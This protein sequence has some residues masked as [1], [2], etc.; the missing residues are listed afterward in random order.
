MKDESDHEFTELSGCKQTV[1]SLGL[2]CVL[3]TVIRRIS[4]SLLL[5]S[6]ATLDLSRRLNRK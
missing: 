6:P 4:N 5:L 2:V 1:V 3:E